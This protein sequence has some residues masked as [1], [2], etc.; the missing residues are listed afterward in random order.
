MDKK[1]PNCLDKIIRPSRGFS[2]AAQVP[3][4][5]ARVCDFDPWY[6]KKKPTKNY[7]TKN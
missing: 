3:D 6:Q 4:W 5:Q 1:R 7:K 2:S